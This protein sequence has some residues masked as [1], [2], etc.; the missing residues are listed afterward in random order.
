MHAE[1]EDVEAPR[2]ARVSLSRSTGRIWI[3]FKLDRPL[4][5]EPSPLMLCLYVDG[6]AEKD[7]IQFGLT[8]AR[9]ELRRYFVI[10][11]AV[12]HLHELAGEGFA[13]GS[14]VIVAP[15]DEHWLASVRPPMRF[16]ALLMYGADDV[17]ADFPV[18]VLNELV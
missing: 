5:A 16:S 4:P 11:Q 7:H 14:T 12:P 17:H 15:F 10:D 9:G 3:R 13:M 6:K 18:T 2:L 1:P 8:L